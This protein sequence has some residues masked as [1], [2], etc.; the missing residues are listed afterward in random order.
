MTLSI[1]HRLIPATLAVLMLGFIVAASLAPDTGVVSAD[2]SCPY[3]NCQSPSTP[4]W[5]STTGYATIGGIIAVVVVAALLAV[6]FMR[7]GGGRPSA[8]PPGA[9]GGGEEAPAEEAPAVEEEAPMEEAP[10]EGGAPPAEGTP[11]WSEDQPE[12]GDINGLMKEIDKL[13]KED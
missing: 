1:K 7:R 8:A 4:F 10:P 9:A 6:Y 3:G 12:S 5:Q 2:S 13:T 11:E